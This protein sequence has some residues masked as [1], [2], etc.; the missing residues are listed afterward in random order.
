[1]VLYLVLLLL[2]IRYPA[3]AV[4]AHWDV[5]LIWVA[6]TVLLQEVSLAR[7]VLQ[8]RVVGSLVVLLGRDVFLFVELHQELLL[9]LAP[10]LK[11]LL[12]PG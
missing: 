7:G 11:H 4:L 9:F 3:L 5:L 2:L 10:A 6:L 12:R 8:A 1:M